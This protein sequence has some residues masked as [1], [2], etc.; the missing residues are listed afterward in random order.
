MIPIFSHTVAFSSSPSSFFSLSPAR[1]V[2]VDQGPRATAVGRRGLRHFGAYFSFF[3]FSLHLLPSGS[4][5]LHIIASKRMKTTDTSLHSTPLHFR[6]LASTHF[7]PTRRSD[8]ASRFSQTS[9]IVPRISQP[10]HTHTSAHACVRA[11]VRAW[12]SC[13]WRARHAPL[14][15]L[16]CQQPARAGTPRFGSS[17]SIA[18]TFASYPTLPYPILS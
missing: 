17:G 8:L 10:S 7:P 1:A 6:R 2:T 12:P 9:P 3:F 14:P 16:P 18:S 5:K 15:Y 4:R 11:C 13:I